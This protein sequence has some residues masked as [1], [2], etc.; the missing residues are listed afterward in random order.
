MLRVREG[1]A[2]ISTSTASL[3]P[4]LQ[5]VVAAVVVADVVV[6]VSC[7][8]ASN[9]QEYNLQS[10][11]LSSRQQQDNIDIDAFASVGV[12]TVLRVEMEI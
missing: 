5:P 2:A 12:T 8:P 9:N 3:S 10:A 11:R 6:V 7:I 1:A 4:Q